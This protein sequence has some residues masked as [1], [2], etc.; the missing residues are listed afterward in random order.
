MRNR[1]IEVQLNLRMTA[2]MFLIKFLFSQVLADE[3]EG[4]DNESVLKKF[5]PYCY[6]PHFDIAEGKC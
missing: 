6:E 1:E 3:S 5:H 2:S 4:Y